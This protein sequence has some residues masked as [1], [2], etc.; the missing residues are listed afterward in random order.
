MRKL[1]TIKQ[2]YTIVKNISFID[3]NKYFI[4]YM[5]E[6]SSFLENVDKLNFKHVE[7]RNIVVPVTRYPRTMLTNEIRKEYRDKKF[8]VYSSKAIPKGKNILFLDLS[9]F[10]EMIEEKLK[11][12]NYRQRAGTILENYLR[13]MFNTIPDGYKKILIY[14]IDKTNPI[15]KFMDRK[16]Y[17]ILNDIKKNGI[18]FDHLFFG[19]IDED[20]TKYRLLVK[21]RQFDIRKIFI[22]LR[23]TSVL[24]SIKEYS[25][26][27]KNIIEKTVET[28]SKDMPI[29]KKDEIKY[30]KI[31]SLYIKDMPPQE[32][33]E[34]FDKVAQSGDKEVDNLNRKKLLIKAVLRHLNANKKT[35][36]KIDKLSLPSQVDNNVRVIDK[37]YLDEMLV[38]EPAKNNS[39]DPT[40]GKYNIP[41]AVNKKAPSHLFEKRKIDF[42][43]NLEKDIKNVLSTVSDR[44]VP[45][46]LKKLE[47][48]HVEEKPTEV[49]KSDVSEV[50][51]TFI[52]K[53]KNVHE[54]SFKIPKINEKD[55]TFLV[56]G[57]KK[58]LINQIILNPISFPKP[59][60]SKFKSAYSSF[61]IWSKRTKYL[62][63]LEIYFGSFKVPLLL[64]LSYVYGWDRTLKRYGIKYYI[65]D[66]KGKKDDYF[67]KISADKYVHFENVDNQLKH[68][69][70]VSF[71]NASP[72][73]YNIDSEFPSKEYFNKLIIEDTGKISSVYLIDVT[74]KNIVEPVTKQV[75]IN[76]RLP[77]D[78]EDII[79]YMASRVV[80]G[81]AQDRNDL[82]K[83]RVRGSEIIVSLMQSLFHGGYS[84]YRAKVLA[85]NE[86]AKLEID[87]NKLLSQVVNSQLVTNMEYSNP[88]EEMATLTRITMVGKNLGGIPDKRAIQGS[89]LN[90]HSSYFGNV[91]PL[92][93]PEGGNIGVVQHLAIDANITSARGLI[94][95]KKIN[96]KEYSGMLS[97]TTCQVP[98][99]ENNDGPR[100]ILLSNQMKQTISL[101]EPEPPAVQSGYES[102]L[103]SYLSDAFIKRSPFD[104]K[105]ISVDDK[106][107]EIQSKKNKETEIIPI[108]PAHLHSGSGVNSLSVFRPTVKEKQAVKENQIIAEG[109]FIKNGMLSMG[110]NLLVGAM[111]YKGYNF[112]DGIVI[113][114]KLVKNDALTSLHGVVLDFTVEK[115]D[116]LLFIA[117]KGTF[118]EPGDI[119]VRKSVGEIESLLG[120]EEEDTEGIYIEGKDLLLR[121]PGGKI[122]DIEVFSNLDPDDYP[123]V[124]KYIEKTDRLHKR[125]GK[126]KYTVRGKNIKGMLIKFKIESPLKIGVGDKL[127]NRYGAKGIISL[128]EKEENMPMTPWG[129][130]LEIIVNPIGIINRINVGQFYELYTGL[131]SKKLGNMIIKSNKND[132]VKI[133][134]KVLPI[135]DKTE[136]RNL[137][138]GFINKIKTASKS[139]FDK[140]KNG[141][142]EHGFFPI[143]IPPFKAPKYDDILKAMSI[144]GLK[145]GYFLNMPEFGTK[146]YNKVPVGYMYFFKLEHI[147]RKKV[148]S[149]NIGPRTKVG[150]PTA[151]KRR[152]GG[153][154]MGEGEVYSL[155]T[156]NAPH[157]LKEF[158]GPLS[159]DL[160]T[161]NEM[162]SDIILK[163][164]TRFKEPRVSPT[165]DL[166]NAYMKVM[167]LG[168]V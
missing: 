128:V 94:N 70:C 139:D 14:T 42:S 87:P 12:K 85:G 52:D 8:I 25:E 164:E 1:S 115:D 89:A 56:N 76:Q 163:G 22:Y 37:Y 98:F 84:E 41:V 13:T 61:H 120:F 123:L 165:K 147:G 4:I 138:S 103:T 125:K 88:T 40:I 57:Q 15:P 99:I 75:L 121:S 148:H 108:T 110:K 127:T 81:Y 54:I 140:I 72:S 161:K 144:L 155:L 55:G 30:K 59:Y 2:Y 46:K 111:E 21:D 106:A 51:A 95:I 126:T 158:F 107:I 17:A 153:Q 19:E 73:K 83:Q 62:Q 133:L 112:E 152:E 27:A 5:G 64:F 157:L 45:L 3:K 142:Q 18:Y 167:G 50:K 44:D 10:L 90:I 39:T 78:L 130:H 166:L 114:D 58:C 49:D 105:V 28:I 6:N 32:I 160:K 92:D 117:E 119:L 7:I 150:Q 159:D 79:E 77:Y 67:V 146:T 20:S 162:I 60:F 154:K 102:I 137:S 129:E 43:I 143:I 16:I 131:I 97:T 68:E 116:R 26:K 132:A 47:I 86:D 31:V 145:D 93:T 71:I 9:P 122:V 96:D 23:R 53:N 69:L 63:Y 141:I 80:I 65:D 151:G 100:V 36:E 134:S 113:S 109:S 66:Q 35:I 101:K 38:K 118:T 29:D 104:G 24:P 33:E 11:P 156:Y 48:N 82:S 74:V 168:R 124:K 91:D 136:N 34:T 135:L 149:R